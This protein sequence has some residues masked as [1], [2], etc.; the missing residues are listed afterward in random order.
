MIYLTSVLG[1]GLLQIWILLGFLT[2]KQVNYNTWDLIKGGGLFIFASSLAI[3]TFIH[4]RKIFKRIHSNETY[5]S[6]FFM[7]FIM[8]FC[9]LGFSSSIDINKD[10]T[11][12]E[13]IQN[14]LQNATQL[15]CSILAVFYGLLVEKRLEKAIR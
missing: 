3:T 15:G 7:F 14:S 1:F 4:H 6:F 8:F 5:W 11:S 12:F 2:F 10:K 9:F 13:I